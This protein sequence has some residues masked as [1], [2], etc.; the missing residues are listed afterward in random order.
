[1]RRVRPSFVVGLDLSLTSTGLLILD[2]HRTVRANVL[3]PPKGWVGLRRLQW[4]RSAVVGAV[5][6]L[7]SKPALIVVEDFAFAQANRA[8]E[9]GGLGFVIRLALAELGHRLMIAPIGVNKKFATG[10]GNAQKSSMM[11]AVYKKWGF[12]TDNDNLADAYSLVKCGQAYLDGAPLGLRACG[13]DN[14]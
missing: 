11:L 1:M 14:D 6:G 8:H 5:D 2:A 13:I 10:K 4:I 9:L 3:S 12:D 7:P